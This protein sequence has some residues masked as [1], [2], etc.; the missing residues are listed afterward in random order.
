MIAA[1]I[2]IAGVLISASVLV[3]VGGAKTTT[4]TTTITTTSTSTLTS[5]TTQTVTSSQSTM[6]TTGSSGGSGGDRQSYQGFTPLVTIPLYH[7]SCG[8]V[9]EMGNLQCLGRPFPRGDAPTF[10]MTSVVN[11]GGSN[12]DHDLRAPL[13]EAAIEAIS[14]VLGREPFSVSFMAYFDSKPGASTTDLS[15]DV[16]EDHPTVS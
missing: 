6:K 2:V 15:N 3:A 13:R 14:P 1:A 16:A 4:T 11:T 7:E 9:A 12:R 8:I 10:D 5:T